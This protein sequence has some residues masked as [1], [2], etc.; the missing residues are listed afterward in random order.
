MRIASARW[1]SRSEYVATPR[2]KPAAAGAPSPTADPAAASAPTL[3]IICRRVMLHLSF[4]SHIVFPCARE[5]KRIGRFGRVHVLGITGKETA[6]LPSRL[7]TDIDFARVTEPG[8]E[9]TP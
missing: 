4:A 6:P 2:W 5:H 9:G 1:N 8:P 7:G 3:E